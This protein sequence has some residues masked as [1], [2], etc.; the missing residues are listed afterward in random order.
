[1]SKWKLFRGWVPLLEGMAWMRITVKRGV[2]L[3][4]VDDHWLPRNKR[5]IFPNRC[6][7]FLIKNLK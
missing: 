5:S 2:Q 3:H 6:S 1:L 7:L 4:A